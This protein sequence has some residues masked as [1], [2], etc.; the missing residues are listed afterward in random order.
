M[1]ACW[2]GPS[3]QNA[4]TPVR[5]L[6]VSEAVR[7]CHNTGDFAKQS[8]FRQGCPNKDGI[9]QYTLSVRSG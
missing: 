6:I 5:I 4:D 7:R 3:L 1:L 2:A 9:L 8:G